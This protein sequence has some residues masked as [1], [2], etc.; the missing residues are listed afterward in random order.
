MTAT[1]VVLALTC[2]FFGG[3]VGFF[4][5]RD[6]NRNQVDEWQALCD[7]LDDDLVD[8]RA[9]LAE[10]ERTIAQLQASIPIVFQAG[11]VAGQL[12][13]AERREAGL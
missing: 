5:G 1:V 8:T 9:E 4:V 12:F 11:E 3:V 13:E 6:I 10:A 2:L 7:E